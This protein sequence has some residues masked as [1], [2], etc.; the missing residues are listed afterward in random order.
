MEQAGGQRVPRGLQPSSPPRRIDLNTARFEQLRAI[1]LSPA[2]ATRFLAARERQR[3]ESPIQVERIHG[4]R[5]G[6]VRS[7]QRAGAWRR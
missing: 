4:L 7:L 3:F 1:G 5:P 6:A 2:E